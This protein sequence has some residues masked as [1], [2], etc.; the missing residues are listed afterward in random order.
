MVFG[1][2]AQSA[3]ICLLKDLPKHI[4]P[5]ARTKKYRSDHNFAL[6]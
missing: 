1:D 6:V 5:V 2:L 4:D 3:F